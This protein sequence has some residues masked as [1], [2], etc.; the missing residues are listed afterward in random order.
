LLSSRGGD[1]DTGRLRPDSTITLA[2]DVRSK[3]DGIPARPP[4][5]PSRIHQID[6]LLNA[7]FA[8]ATA[9]SRPEAAT[10]AQCHRR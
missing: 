8:A 1:A 4:V 6:A 5:L 3:S 7:A 9:A 2:A 10:L